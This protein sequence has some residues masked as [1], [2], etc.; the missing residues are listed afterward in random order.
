LRLRFGFEHGEPV[1]GWLEIGSFLDDAI[2]GICVHE[3]D[4]VLKKSQ[5]T[6]CQR[7]VN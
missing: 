2:G 5:G 3:S 4:G 1:R 6:R 7:S